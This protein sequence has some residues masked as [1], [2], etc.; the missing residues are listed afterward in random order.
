MT[1][2]T[3]R[4]IVAT[5]IRR[6][7]DEPLALVRAFEATFA[8][9]WKRTRLTLGDVTLT[10]IVDRVLHIACERFAFLA[11]LELLEGGPRWTDAASAAG[12][13][14]ARLAE[15]LELVLVDF[16]SVLGNLT[17]EILTPALHAEISR[18]SG[19]REAS[20]EPRS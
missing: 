16:L 18:S 4:A 1:D 2:T 10:A 3:H 11:S 19:H 13:S 7:P 20:E 5:W 12:M 14:R 9:L 17:A 6:A 8:A 15:G